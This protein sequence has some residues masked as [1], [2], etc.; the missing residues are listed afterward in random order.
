M[1]NRVIIGGQ[2]G[3]E[4]KGKIIDAFGAGFD[5]VLR[6]QGGANAGHTIQVGARE[7]V[8]HLIPSGIFREGVRCYLGNGMVIDPWAL[9]DEILAL[10]E[11]GIKVRDRLFVSSAAQLLMPY[12]KR[13]DEQRET[14]RKRKSIG[15]TGRGIGPAYQDKLQRSGLR[16]GDLTLSLEKLER[17]A[18]EHILEANEI[19][20]GQ[21]DAEPLP[22][23]LLAEELVILAQ[24]LRPMIVDGFTAPLIEKEK[25]SGR[26]NYYWICWFNFPALWHFFNCFVA[27]RNSWS[28]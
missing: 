19:L 16:L 25:I 7:H 5:W 21:Y 17:T 15:T 22:A 27:C 24:T 14:Q 12:H 23:K 11:H 26:Q 4:G 9:R 13:M 1:E 10:E 3:D 18:I 28:G 6:Y 2:W 8:V 20:A